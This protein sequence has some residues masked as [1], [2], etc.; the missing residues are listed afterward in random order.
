[1][2][3]VVFSETTGEVRG[4]VE[5]NGVAY[6]VVGSYLSLISSTGVKTDLG[7]VGGS[8]RVSITTDGISVIIVNG[9]TTGYY[10]NTSTTAFSTITLPANAYTITYLDTYIVFSSDG[11]RWY[12]SEVKDSDSFNALDFA[13]A[14]KSPDNLI[15]IWEDHGELILFGE[16]TIEPWF[17]SGDVDFAFGQNT[18]GIVER[19][20]RA[21]FSVAKED[22]TLFFLGDDLAVYRL[23][24]Y[25]PIRISSDSVDAQLAE[26]RMGGYHEALDETYGLVYVEHGHKFYQ[27]T[28]PGHVT[29]VFNVATKEWHQNK[30]WNYATHHATCYI[31]CYGKH[32]IGALDGKIYQMSREFYS[33]GDQ[34]LRR[35]RRSNCFSSDDSITHWKMIKL[36]F[37][38]GTTKVLTGQGSDPKVVIRWSYDYGRTWRS[39]KH[40]PLGSAGNYITKAITR[41]C[42]A[43]RARTI[44]IYVTDPVP[45]FLL[46]AFAE[47]H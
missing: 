38:F 41:S 15:A 47:V 29:L 20:L 32:L 13:S 35:L 5:L 3:S 34:P 43:S 12:A 16:H 17:D 24:G 9:S 30:H 2:G 36:I 45:F 44:E 46:D 14:V 37:D 22:N 27:L 21:R 6:F 19:G 18:A 40:L 39:E 11:E 8:G 26:L 7:Y 10:Y 28:V 31:E 4:A 23:E 42:G 33:D 25:Q 1:M